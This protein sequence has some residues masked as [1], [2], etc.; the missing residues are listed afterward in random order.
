MCDCF[1]CPTGLNGI[2]CQYRQSK[3][4]RH[5]GNAPSSSCKYYL[6]HVPQS[7]RFYTYFVKIEYR[8]NHTFSRWKWGV[9]VSSST[10]CIYKECTSFCD[11]CVDIIWTCFDLSSGLEGRSG[12]NRGTCCCGCLGDSRLFLVEKTKRKV[13]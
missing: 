2:R 3:V 13:Q 7:N 11:E 6:I 5:A 12:C 9:H 1:S 8:T 4:Q 10:I